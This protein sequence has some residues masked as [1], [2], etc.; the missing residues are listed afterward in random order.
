[1]GERVVD[2]WAVFDAHQTHAGRRYLEQE[3]A[4]VAAVA[5]AATQDALALVLAE[6]DAF[7]QR[8]TEP[9][10]VK[11]SQAESMRARIVSRL[12]GG[13]SNE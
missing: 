3:E 7:I 11:R 9:G 6:V 12:G 2:A 4:G 8:D 10:S 13:D 1:M 5:A